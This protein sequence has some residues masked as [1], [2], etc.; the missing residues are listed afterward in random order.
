MRKVFSILTILCLLTLTGTV[1]AVSAAEE[2]SQSAPGIEMADPAAIRFAIGDE[3]EYE[4]PID[5]MEVIGRYNVTIDPTENFTVEPINLDDPLEVEGDT[6]IGALD[7]VA[8][9]EGLNYTTYYYTVSDRLVVDSI[10]EYVYEEDQ[11]WYVLNDLNETFHETDTDARDH[12]LTD[13][14]TFWF[15]YCDLSD[16]DPRY[17]SRTDRAVAGLSITVT[18]GEGNVTPTPTVNVTPEVTENATPTSTIPGVLIPTPTTTPENVT[19]VTTD[20][21]TPGPTENVTPM[22][23]PAGQMDL[24][25]VIDE[26]G[27]LSIMA[28][29]ISVTDLAATLQNEGPYTVFAPANDA[30]GNLTPEVIAG[31]LTD[32]NVRTQVVSNHVVNGSYTAA[33]LLNMTE[34]GNTTTL[35]T[36]AGE[37]LT[38]SESGG[39]LMVDNATISALEIN[40][41]NGIVHVIDRVLVPPTRR[42][43]R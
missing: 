13:G 6:P 5:T 4:L 14:E 38:V 12:N 2:T 43:N 20:N 34:G 18:F 22:P 17:E 11:I 16:Y 32:D 40:A 24:G 41:S 21:V 10:G 19:P 1:L 7:A 8:R 35:T 39:L 26:D 27:N 25:E 15:I 29:L 36:L 3:L 9:S 33:E 31:I 30:F 42:D 23:T 37:N 28:G